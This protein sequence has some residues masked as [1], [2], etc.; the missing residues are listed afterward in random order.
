MFL[1]SSKRKWRWLL[2]AVVLIAV[3]IVQAPILRGL[4]GLL[5]VDQPTEEFDYV[6]LLAWG[7]QAEGDR[8]YDVAGD[9]HREK[10]SRR[11]LLVGQRPSRIEKVGVMQPLAAISRRELGARG[12]PPEAVSLIRGGQWNDWANARS[13]AAWLGDHPGKSVLLL[14][15][16]FHSAQVRHV[17]DAVL[18]VDEAARVR[19]RA[20]PSRQYD[21]TNWWTVRGGYREFGARWLM[22]IQSWLGGGDVPQ[23]P[24]K[25]ADEY[26]R[27]FLQTLPEGTR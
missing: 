15:S 16:Q 7:Y 22:R 17:L 5:I 21:N 12:V 13:L 2:A 6:C 14:C 4:A 10:P 19:I 24:E 18:D 11:I 8:C 27:D 23:S 3:W 20:L 1:G 9:L 26:R 25:S